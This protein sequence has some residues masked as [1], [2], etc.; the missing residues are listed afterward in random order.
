MSVAR[1][2]DELY[3]CTSDSEAKSAILSGDLFLSDGEVAI[4][5][6]GT[7][8]DEYAV[9]LMEFSVERFHRLKREIEIEKILEEE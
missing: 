8:D 4:N 9:I 2:A 5:I 7:G 6:G 3:G 1:F